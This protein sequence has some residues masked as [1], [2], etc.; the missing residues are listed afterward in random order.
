PV[1]YAPAGSVAAAAARR[2]S[3]ALVDR[4]RGQVG[5]TTRFGP[6][7]PFVDHGGHRPDPARI[8]EYEVE[9]KFNVE[10]LVDCE[11]Q[12]RCR[13]RVA[14]G[15][16]EVVVRTELV[17][18]QQPFPKLRELRFGR[19]RHRIGTRVHGGRRDRTELLEQLDKLGA[20]R[21]AGW[22]SRD[23]FDEQEAPRQLHGLYAL[24]KERGDVTVA[25]LRIRHPDYRRGHHL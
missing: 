9:A 15:Q 11:D 13:Q 2:A 18:L 1:Q 3:D 12:L 6:V 7:S 21:L 5:T 10:Q 16:E 23:P 14:A 25:Q 4:V 20:Q 22:S 19:S 8:A 17:L 24:T